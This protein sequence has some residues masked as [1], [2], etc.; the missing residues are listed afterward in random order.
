M[1]AKI[2][3]KLLALLIVTALIL[4]ALITWKLTHQ[5]PQQN[6]P[7]PVVNAIQ[8]DWQDVTSEKSFVAKIE[9]RDRV[10]LRARVTGF[11]QA[12]LFKEGDYVEK[13]QPLFIIERVNFESAVKE[14]QAN[15]D[16]AA[17]RAKNAQIQYN[18]TNNLYRTKDVSR[19]RLD[20]DEATHVAA[21]ADLT[22][23]EARLEIAKQ[24]LEYTVIKAPIQGRIGEAFFSVGELIGPQSG[25]LATIV[26]VDPMDAVFSVSENELLKARRQFLTTND[27]EALF[28]TADDYQYPETGTINF[29]DVALDEGMNTLKMKVSFPNPEHRLIPGQYGRVIL[30]SKKPIKML[31]I[32]Q[33]AVQHTTSDEFVL[34]VIVNHLFDILVYVQN[35]RRKVP[36]FEE[37]DGTIR[38]E[39]WNYTPTGNL[40]DLSPAPSGLRWH[41]PRAWCQH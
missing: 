10:G 41:D 22:Q 11:L 19:A 40:R 21:K 4:I 32:P 13:D 27:T 36:L 28:M 25:L 16:R 2:N 20:D 5:S 15:F 35:T 23:M 31:V 29:I 17:A 6:A 38:D 30:K 26:T 8:I 14:A 39:L 7:I 33:K 3:K 1:T 34:V 24:E 18:R 37:F 12:R 9:S